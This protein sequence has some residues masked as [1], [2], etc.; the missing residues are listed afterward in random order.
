MCCGLVK[1]SS[2]ECLSTLQHRLKLSKSQEWSLID[3][4]Q[5]EIITITVCW[6]VSNDFWSTYIVKVELRVRITAGCYVLVLVSSWVY[7]YWLLCY[8][9]ITYSSISVVLNGYLL[10]DV[11]LDHNTNYISCQLCYACQQWEWDGVNV[12][13]FFI[14]LLALPEWCVIL[15]GS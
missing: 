1:F 8:K 9:F 6:W 2:I 13:L 10:L 14:S 7:F 12:V 5:Y 11:Q 3:K 15:L 4:V